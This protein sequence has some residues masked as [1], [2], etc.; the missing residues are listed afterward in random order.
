MIITNLRSSSISTF[1]GCPMAWFFQYNL[2]WEDSTNKAAVKGTIVHAV[3][4]LLALLKKAH[5][6]GKKSI[7][8]DMGIKRLNVKDYLD[9]DNSL[10]RLTSKL[11]NLNR[12][13]YGDLA[14]KDQD[15][16]D[17]VKW[18][19]K[20]L[21]SWEGKFDPRTRNIIQAEDFFDIEIMQP[22]STYNYELSDGTILNGFFS[23]KGTIDLVT[24]ADKN[25]IEIIDYKTGK[26]KDSNTGDIKEI[27]DIKEDIQP[28]MYHYVLSQQYP[29]AQIIVTMLYINDGGPYTVYYDK[30]DIAKTEKIIKNYYQTIKAASPTCN[31]SWKCN[32][33]CSFGMSTFEGTKILPLNHGWPL[34]QFDQLSYVLNYETEEQVLANMSNKNLGE[35]LNAYVQG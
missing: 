4:E 29:D 20:T 6:D 10:D 18:V 24:W 31:K 33:F 21:D 15:E 28:R 7:T 35:V 2:G 17:C 25:I 14:W 8:T 9:T 12:K 34:T 11:Y 13:K 27:K 26:R 1:K 3:L 5:Q 32:R 22:W 19:Y 30:S 23:I 16:K